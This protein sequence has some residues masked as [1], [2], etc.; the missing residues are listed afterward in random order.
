[1]TPIVQRMGLPQK[2][3]ATSRQMMPTVINCPSNARGLRQRPPYP[4]SFVRG[5]P[6]TRRSASARRASRSRRLNSFVPFV[7]QLHVVLRHRPRSISRRSTAPCK[8]VLLVQRAILNRLHSGSSGFRVHAKAK[9]PNRLQPT[10]SNAR[11]L[12]ASRW[13]ATCLA[14]RQDFEQ[15][16][17]LPLLDEGMPQGKLSLDLVAV[18]PALSLAQHVALCRRART[19]SGGRHA[20]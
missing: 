14:L 9:G 1:M 20:R 12:P 11:R 7:E 3:A 10:E 6:Y 16:A 19:G 18:P 13:L 4:T 2:R 8:A 15:V 17:N 5:L